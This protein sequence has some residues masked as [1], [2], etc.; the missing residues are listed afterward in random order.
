MK[1]LNRGNQAGLVSIGCT[2]VFWIY[3]SIPIAASRVPASPYV[4]FVVLL[5][6]FSLLL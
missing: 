2:L 1:I 4:T 6:S 5:R 3:I